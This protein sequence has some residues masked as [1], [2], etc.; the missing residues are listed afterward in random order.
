MSS[1][2]GEGA[3]DV[4]R[5]ELANEAE[6]ATLEYGPV[7]VDGDDGGEDENEEGALPVIRVLDEGHDVGKDEEHNDQ[8]QADQQ[9]GLGPGVILGS[10]IMGLS[11]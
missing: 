4:L 9:S 1:L 3:A 6:Q 7:D 5:W 2:A 10:Q 11:K 8:G